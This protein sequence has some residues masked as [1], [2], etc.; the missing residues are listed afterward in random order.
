MLRSQ[1]QRQTSNVDSVIA[2]NHNSNLNI[3]LRCKDFPFRSLVPQKWEPMIASQEWKGLEIRSVAEGKGVFATVTFQKNDVI[4]NYG[5]KFLTEEYAKTFL[6]P[7]EEK[8]N[9]L[10]EMRE[11]FQGNWVN[12]YLNH[13]SCSTK[14]FFGKYIN[15]SKLHPNLT[16]KIY[17]T[18]DIK[19]DFLFFAKM[20]I[21]KGTE[22]VWNYGSNFS[23]VNSCVNSCK[24]CKKL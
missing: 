9:Y 10:V 5:G 18:K 23:G 8:C 22:L 7:Y 3:P 16:F 2:P 11:N 19:L 24:K 1:I 12:F 6:L 15:H 17:V 13:D 21:L 4:C 14:F 20:R